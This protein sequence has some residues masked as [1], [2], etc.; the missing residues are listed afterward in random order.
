MN[1]RVKILLCGFVL[2]GGCTEEPK[3]RSVQELLDNPIM[4]EA[5][6]VSCA[7]DRNETR[8]D[9]ECMNARQA[10]TIIEAK[11]ERAK[12]DAFEAESDR[13]RQ[14]LRRTQQA[15]AEARRRSEAAER[16][17]KEAA[18]LAQFGE[19]PPPEDGETAVDDS[20]LNAPVMVIPKAEEDAGPATEESQPPMDGGN[21]PVAETEP[22]SD[23]SAIRDELRRRNEE[24]GD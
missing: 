9:A 19:L 18:Y 17:R 8:Y 16:M 6:V 24:P 2:L 20:A 14:A 5:T 15:A 21:A 4:L 1:N 13:K 23:L 11:E 12:R 3:P 7:Q 22:P 10:V